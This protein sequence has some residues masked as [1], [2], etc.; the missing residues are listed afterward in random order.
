MNAKDYC[1]EDFIC[2][3]SFQRYCRGESE[4]DTRFWDAFLQHHPHK[5]S[6]AADAKKIIDLL[7]GHQG[8]VGQQLDHLKDGIR[9][10]EQLQSAI[11]PRRGSIVRPWIG[12]A[13]A[14][15]AAMVLITVGYSWLRVARPALA[16]PV[17]ATTTAVFSSGNEPRKT[18]VLPDNSVITLRSHS[19][20]TL[21]DGFGH[22]NREL[23]L[24]GE[25]FFDVVHNSGHPFIVHTADAN[26]EVLGTVFNVSAYPDDHH[27]ETALFRGKVS[28]TSH[29]HPGQKIILTP[30]KKI[31]ISDDRQNKLQP[32]QITSLLSDPVSHKASEIAWVRNRLKIEDEPLSQIAARLQDWYGISIGFADQEVKEY[33]YSG[34][35]ESETVIKALEAL[36]LSYPFSFRVEKE[37]IIIGK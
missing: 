1:V 23:T 15:V 9:R 22:A 17:V 33:R 16:L 32:P 18:I 12:Y 29:D 34:T 4:K 10:Y 5:A 11:T 24:S 6:Q 14:A 27:T 31:V 7:N 13:A 8:H 2:D 28:V 35:F 21:A 25:G 26:I 30:S 19:S 3:E 20:L 36:Q 37:K